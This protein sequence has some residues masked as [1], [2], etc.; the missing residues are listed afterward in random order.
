MSFVN[1]NRG[2]FRRLVA[3]IWKVIKAYL[4][5]VGLFWTIVPALFG[6]LIYVSVKKKDDLKPAVEVSRPQEPMILDLKLEGVVDEGLD[7]GSTGI[8]QRLFE[9]TDRIYLLDFLGKIRHAKEDPMVH[10]LFLQ[11]DNFMASKNQIRELRNSLMDFKESGKEVWC[12]A[13]DL[14]SNTFLLTSICSRFDLSPAGS[15]ELL[16]PAFRL[17]YF[18]DALKKLGVGVD[19]LRAGSFKNAFEPFVS[20]EPSAETLE[21]YRWLEGDLRTT[22]LQESL[23]KGRF[24]AS[25]DQ[26]RE[27]FKKS[28]YTGLDAKSLGIVND[29]SQL[30]QTKAAFLAA[31]S[32]EKKLQYQDFDD[33]GFDH[34]TWNLIDASKKVISYIHLAG[35]IELY[36]TS[37]DGE[38]IIPEKVQK[39]LKWS[40]ENQDVAAILLRIDSPGGS[41][42]ASDMI[43]SAI[44]DANQ[45]KPVI[46]SMGS[47]AASGGYYIASAA[48]KIIAD[49][50]T[51]TGSIGV[52]GLMTNFS[53]FQEKYGVSFHTVTSSDRKT[54]VNPGK[55]LSEDDRKVLNHGIDN[56]YELFLSRVSESRGK[57]RNEIHE[58][59]Q[60]K[61]WTGRQALDLQLVDQLGGMREALAESKIAAGLDPNKL[62]PIVSPQ[63]DFDLA[64]CILDSMNV[65]KCLSAASSTHINPLNTKL[66][67]LL[68]EEIAKSLPAKDLS[69]ILNML[70]TS[71]KPSAQARL[72]GVTI[73]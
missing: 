50:F 25:I 61:V 68:S 65:R 70:Q 48:R 28:L 2:F 40:L 36:G 22:L 26:V 5:G 34:G 58:I 43:W 67:F 42:L 37:Q 1:E 19:V 4:I 9:M 21:M 66:N 38:S 12:W 59:A 55:T 69:L 56:I 15:V 72:V 47:M 41:A 54:I 16:G 35:D 10:G 32:K 30:A 51:V 53:Q 60:G 6:I 62:Y 31:A 3:G 27:W 20:N 18:G 64:Q 13:S 11:V 8:F 44:K 49:P 46:V 52:I 23:L 39:D 24:T 33:Y 57:S 29:L 7:E 73:D 17:M 71:K 45:Q 14:D 63:E